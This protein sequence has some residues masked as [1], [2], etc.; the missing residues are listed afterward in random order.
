MQGVDPEAWSA[1]RENMYG[2]D[3]VLFNVDDDFVAQCQTPL[4]VLMGNDLYHP[5][6]A[7]RMVANAAPN[8]EFIEDWKE[9]EARTEA[10]A[11][12]AAF[13]ARHTP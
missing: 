7:S 2:G 5:Q 3:K 10:M 13:L 9:G 8:V 1:F 11:A 6:S 4:L 12:F